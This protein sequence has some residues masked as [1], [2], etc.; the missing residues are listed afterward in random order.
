MS[1]TGTTKAGQEQTYTADNV[2]NLKVCKLGL[3]AELLDDSSILASGQPRVV[4]RFG[5]RDD[6]LARSKDESGRFG[7]TNSHDDRSET[8]NKRFKTVSAKK[9]SIMGSKCN[10]FSLSAPF[11]RETACSSDRNKTNLWIVLGV[12]C[13]KR[14]RLQ[15]ESTIQ[16]DRADNVSEEI[17][18]QSFA[19]EIGEH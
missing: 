2:L 1:D 4:F 17:V 3:E 5:A 18:R 14:D 11:E 15:I 8:L 7:F 12:A 6:D 10:S 13:V 9:S 16:V 19:N